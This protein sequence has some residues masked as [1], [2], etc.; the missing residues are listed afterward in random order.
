MKKRLIVKHPEILARKVLKLSI[1]VLS[2]A[3][4]MIARGPKQGQPANLRSVLESTGS[5]AWDHSMDM[6]TTQA[7]PS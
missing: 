3:G 7:G 1:I 4:K 6:K 5:R 2:Q